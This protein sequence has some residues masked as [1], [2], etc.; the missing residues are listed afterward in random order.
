[1]FKQI[2]KNLYTVSRKAGKCASVLNDID[3]LARG[4]ISRYLKRK[5][6]RKI[7]SKVNKTINKIF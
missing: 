2:T 6:K 4:D 5:N 7:M 1:M 3:T